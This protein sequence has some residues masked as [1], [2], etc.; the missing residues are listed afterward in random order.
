VFASGGVNDYWNKNI[1]QITNPSPGQYCIWLTDGLVARNAVAGLVVGGYPGFVRATAGAASWMDCPGDQDVS[2]V[3]TN[4]Q[5][6]ALTNS[7]FF[8]VIN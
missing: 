3:F 2:A 5:N 4:A 1:E 8:I 7:D 6:T